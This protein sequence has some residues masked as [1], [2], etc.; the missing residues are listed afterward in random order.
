[1][2][3]LQCR[4]KEWARSGD[5]CSGYFQI[6]TAASEIVVSLGTVERRF[7][8]SDA[9]TKDLCGHRQRAS[10]RGDLSTDGLDVAAAL[11]PREDGV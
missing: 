2:E 10:G 11:S 8:S 4:G 7:N 1:M 3:M 9:R 6:G 5:R